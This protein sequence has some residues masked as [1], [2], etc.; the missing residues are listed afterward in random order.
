MKTLLVNA[1][2]QLEVSEIP[3]PKYTSKQALVKTISCG[4]CGTDATII[5]AGFKGFPRKSYPLMLGHEGVGRVVEVGSE[6]TSFKVGDIVLLPFNDADEELYGSLGSAWGAFSEY[7]V[8]H[9]KAAYQEGEVPEVAFAQQ[10][11]PE[12]IDPVDAVMLVT[13]REVYSTIKYFGIHSEDSVVVFGSGPVAVTF[14]KIM[15]LMGV[16]SIIGIARSEEKR[17]LL[18]ENGA[19]AAFNSR[20]ADVTNEI[21]MLY[22]DGVKYVLDAVG[23]VEII[24]QAMELIE[25]RGEILC[26]GVPKYDQMQLDW[27]KAPYNWKLNFQQMPSKLEESKAYGQILDWIRAGKINLKDFISDYFEFE[28]VL[29]AFEKY[30]NHRILK[31]A[32]ITYLK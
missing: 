12:N 13:L 20:E 25:D 15:S 4:I 28:S 11:V 29:D 32:I 19:T 14:I 2:G 21:R 17:R 30:M 24:N 1:D 9:D 16:Q 26:Y 10:I 3:V 27:S 31:K 7:G 8:I 23:T 5:Q 18:L 6:V 22:P